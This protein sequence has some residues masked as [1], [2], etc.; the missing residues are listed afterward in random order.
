M[1]WIDPGAARPAA[2][3]SVRSITLLRRLLIPLA[4]TG[5]VI[6]GAWLAIL[7]SAPGIAWADAQ[8]KLAQIRTIRFLER[9]STPEAPA[10]VAGP[11]EREGEEFETT[12]DDAESPRRYFIRGRFLKRVEMLDEQGKV[13]DIAISDANAGKHVSIEPAEK[14]FVVL[15]TQVWIDRESGKQTEEPINPTPDEDYFQHFGEVPPEAVVRLP[16]RQI[17]GRETVGFQWK[18]ETET[19]GI[20]QTWTRTYWVDPQTKAF[21][22]V[23]I[24]ARFSDP[25]VAPSD[26]VQ[27]DFV[28]DAEMP[29]SLFRV[30]PPEGY[31]VTTEPVY[32]IRL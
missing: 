30:E 29:D 25:H 9:R 27:T 13:L 16:A 24:S 3:S 26:W 22:R 31:S 18:E 28:Y 4:G 8:Q 32:G 6:G 11:P 23:E 1:R 15:G 17:D 14:K 12:E 10:K 21:V 20:T 5:L 2:N 19:K 7:P